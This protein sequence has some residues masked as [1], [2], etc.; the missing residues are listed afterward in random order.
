MLVRNIIFIVLILMLGIGCKSKKNGQ[1]QIKMK[2]RSSKY[3]I[4]K[5]DKYQLDAEWF[6]GKGNVK[7]TEKGKSNSA[8]IYIRM[9]KDSVIWAAVKKLGFEAGRA[10]VTTDSIFLMNRLNKT[11]YAKPI[12]YMRD[13]L[14]LSSSGD[15]LTDFRLLYDLMLGNP[16]YMKDGKY[17]VEMFEAQYELSKETDGLET[18]YWL[19]GFNFLLKKMTFQQTGESRVASCTFEDYKS[20]EEDQLF[21]YIRKLNLYS[22]ETGEL[23]VDLNYKSVTFNKPVSIKFDIPDRYEKVD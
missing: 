10:M 21:S 18:K 9:R 14:G 6:S 3:L 19:N 20:I 15:N 11:Y 23:K 7:I 1:T 4:D 13:M 12:S 16:V 5:L 22:S 8:K 17:D 2:K